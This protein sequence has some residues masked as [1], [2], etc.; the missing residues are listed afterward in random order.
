M[1]V[2]SG[3]SRLLATAVAGALVTPALVFNAPVARADTVGYLINITV[4][5]AY[6]FPNAD[7]AVS[8]GYSICDRIR[9]GLSYAP[10]LAGVMTDL[11]TND[12]YQAAYLINQAAEMLCP[13][14]I[15]QLRQSAA[16]TVVP[17]QA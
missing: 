16:G 10:L 2:D 9:Q 5:P 11:S 8:Y 13:A 3:T 17:A 15:W 7:A 12:E 14:E 1:A 6:N 4:R